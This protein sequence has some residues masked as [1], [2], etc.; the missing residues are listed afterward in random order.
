VR[1][2]RRA[3]TEVL[4]WAQG[5]AHS[6]IPGGDMTELPLTVYTPS[7][8]LRDPKRLV[9]EMFRDLAASRELAWRLFI[10]D[11]SAQYRQS[12]L[13]YVWVFIPP[14]VASLPFVYLNE[15]G[16][17]KMG[18][19]PV[20]FG[21][22]AIIGTIIW[23]VFVDAINAPLRTVTQARPM[24]ARINLPREAILLSGLAQ[25][26][27]GFLVRL[28]LLLGVLAWFRIAPPATAL[29]FPIGILSLILVGFV[30][31][32]L[33]TPMGLLYNDVQQT[34]PIATTFLMLLTPVVYPVPVSGFAA[35][36]AALNPLTSLVTATRDW[37]TVGS[38]TQMAAFTIIT[39]IAA[40]GLFSGWIVL[41]V[42]MPHLIAR[43]GS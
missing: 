5:L 8:P 11:V 32:I 3:P 9:R 13:G 38:T 18:D 17:V 1:E 4:D 30:L 39:L 26:L 22:Y 40:A 2:Q 43:I 14:L 29:L 12:I 28:V 41:R 6:R 10:R 27:F 20:P 25:V 21:A 24:L 23:Q 31:G 15:Q 42:A 7:S 19:T 16:I 34:L 33:I 35:T 36:V 37:L